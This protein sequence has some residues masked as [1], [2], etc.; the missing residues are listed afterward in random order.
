MCLC[1]CVCVCVHIYYTSSSSLPWA[2]KLVGR[3]LFV[4]GFCL[5]TLSVHLAPPPPPPPPPP[6]T[7]QCIVCVGSGGLFLRHRTKPA[8]AP[9][10]ALSAFVGQDG[11]EEFK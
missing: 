1:V 6:L 10:W 11:L 5:L 2:A 8:C 7:V 4:C 3:R 9:W